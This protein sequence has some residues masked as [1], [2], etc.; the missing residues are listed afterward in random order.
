M[1]ENISHWCD[2]NKML[3]NVSK[4]KKMCLCSKHKLSVMCNEP[5]N[6]FI[7]NQ[8]INESQREQVLGIFVDATLSWSDHIKYVIKNFKVNSSFSSTKK[9]QEIFK[10]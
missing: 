9:D 3:I 2:E 6:I 5:F 8:Y 10:S 7:N 4:I 1:L